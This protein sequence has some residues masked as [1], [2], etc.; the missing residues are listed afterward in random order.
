MPNQAHAAAVDHGVD[1]RLAAEC[2]D[3][4]PQRREPVVLARIASPEG[5]VVLVQNS[6]FGGNEIV[7]F[8]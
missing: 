5:D 1:L 7:L 3:V 8:R 6:A 4:T 2:L